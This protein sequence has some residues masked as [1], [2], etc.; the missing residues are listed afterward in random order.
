[1]FK[2]LYT[3]VGAAF[4]S[5]PFP[6][7]HIY[8]PASPPI[9]RHY[10]GTTPLLTTSL[11][12]SVTHFTSASPAAF[13]IS[14]ATPDGPAALPLFA[15]AIASLTSDNDI[16]LS[17]TDASSLFITSVLPILSLLQSN[18]SLISCS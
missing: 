17:S 2:Q 5:V 16:S 13:N 4:Q 1:M 7:I 14:A 10:T 3:S 9:Y 11:Q 15:L 18:S 6:F 8:H 12:I